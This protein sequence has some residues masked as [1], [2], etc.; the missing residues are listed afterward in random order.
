MK[1]ILLIEDNLH[2][3]ENATELLELAGYEVISAANGMIGVQLAKSE[4][5]DII[6]SDVMMPVLDG[7]GVF[8]ELKKDETTKNIPFVFVTSSVEKKEMESATNKGADGYIKKPFDEEDLYSTI[9]KILK[10]EK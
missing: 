7:H 3:R 2:I 10:G 5:P 9:E 6:L 4:L 1:K 8:A